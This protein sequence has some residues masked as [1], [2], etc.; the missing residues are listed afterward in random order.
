MIGVLA[1]RNNL[2]VKNAT[3]S[4]KKKNKTKPNTTSSTKNFT[5]LKVSTRCPV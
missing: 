5:P 3:L 2:R 4:V 1:I